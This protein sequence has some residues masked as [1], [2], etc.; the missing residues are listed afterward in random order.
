MNSKKIITKNHS[1]EP[2]IMDFGNRKVSQQNFSKIVALPKM[3][4]TNCG[5]ES[6]V[7]V[8]LVQTGKEKFIKLS[9]S[10]IGDERS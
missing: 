6:Q 7:N 5:I 1:S 9:P 4:L 3:A 2:V 8:K 10:P